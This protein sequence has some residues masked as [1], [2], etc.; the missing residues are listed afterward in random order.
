ME[1]GEGIGEHH[2]PT[3]GWSGV[4]EEQQAVRSGQLEA[5]LGGTEELREVR[6]CTTGQGGV[7]WT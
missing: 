1:G 5:G 4:G 7:G 6:S 3:E 2:C